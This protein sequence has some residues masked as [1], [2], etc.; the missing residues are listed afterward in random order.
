MAL[1]TATPLKKAPQ[2]VLV[3]DD[4]QPVA[5]LFRTE[6]EKLGY[7]VDTAS[8]G[9][10]GLDKAKHQKPNLV[11]LDMIMPKVSGREFLERLRVE[12]STFAVPVMIVSHLESDYE[13]KRCEEL[14]IAC[15]LVKHQH[16]VSSII[17]EAKSI[18]EKR[19]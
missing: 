19:A 15:F 6:L 16:S 10:E 2:R 18:L 7:V 12:K 4:D 9:A 5:T 1:S 17:A 14:G 11:I 13:K 8:N 3:V